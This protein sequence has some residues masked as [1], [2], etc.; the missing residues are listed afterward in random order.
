VEWGHTTPPFI[1]DVHSS[2]KEVANSSLRSI[3]RRK[4]NWLAVTS[5]TFDVDAGRTEQA[6]DIS[7]RRPGRR[8]GIFEE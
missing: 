5:W 2:P 1:T 8:A 3:S 4:I 6:H 7:V